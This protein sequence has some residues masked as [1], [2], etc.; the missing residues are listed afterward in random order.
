[1]KRSTALVL[2]V[3]VS[4]G[5]LVLGGPTCTSSV[6][7]VGQIS[8]VIHEPSVTL[9]DAVEDGDECVY[10][11]SAPDDDASS[12]SSDSI[13]KSSRYE[14]GAAGDWSWSFSLRTRYSEVESDLAVRTLGREGRIRSWTT[15][16]GACLVGDRWPV[17]LRVPHWSWEG[18]GAYSE[19]SG[20]N[21]G[22]QV[23]PQYF[24][25]KEDSEVVN[26]SVFAV[27]GY[28]KTWFKDDPGI[29][30]A[31]YATW[32]VGARI[33]KSIGIGRL[34]LGYIYQPWINLDGD[35]IH[36]VDAELNGSDT[37]DCHAATLGYTVGFGEGF[38]GSLAATWEYTEDL[39]DQYD[40][41]E[42]L[43]RA[44]L[45][46]GTECWSVEASY[47]RTIASDDYAAWDAGLAVSV[48]W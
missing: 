46:Y 2:V 16:L 7:I 24:I 1:M 23:M 4:L 36:G 26:L 21:L 6:P 28:E 18:Y 35:T 31:S 13:P 15:D 25:M 9:E 11:D 22:L 47:G 3:A 37:I 38:Y 32:G 12:G 48:R 29:E 39:P 17:G 42:Y 10:P 27:A 45:G 41:D 40:S 43:G 20:E 14:P 33:G 30:D 5:S 8:S 34:S 44:T 19:L